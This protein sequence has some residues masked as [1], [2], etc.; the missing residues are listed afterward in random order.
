MLAALEY[1][2]LVFWATWL[3]SYAGAGGVDMFRSSLGFVAAIWALQE[4]LGEHGAQGTG[5]PSSPK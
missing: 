2:S 4:G 5:K 3:S 1:S